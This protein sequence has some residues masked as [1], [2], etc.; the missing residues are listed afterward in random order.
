MKNPNGYGSVFKL[1]GKRRNPF[2]V[3]ITVGWE[4]NEKT[5]KVKQKY[6]N[7]GYYK[8]RSE[9]MIALAEYNKN[10]Y[11]I[12]VRKVTFSE[13]YDMWFKEK[14]KNST[15][16]NGSRGYVAAFNYS[17]DMHNMAFMDIRKSHMQ[18]VIDN[19]DKS[20]STKSITKTLYSQL[21]K[22]AAE[23]DIVDKNYSEFVSV[24]K[25]QHRSKKQPFSDA[26][27]QILWDNLE[28]IENVD[29]ALIMIYTGL[30]PGE[31]IL[32]E[33]DNINLEERYFTGGIKTNA[34]KERII[35]INKKIH[36]LIEKRMDDN[37]KYLFVNK[38]GNK[39]TYSSFRQDRWVPLMEKLKLDHGAHECRHTFA[40]LMDNANANKLSIKK[41]MGHASSDI[42]DKVYTHKNIEEL[43]KA[44]DLI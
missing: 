30:R 39:I 11:D 16:T 3:R 6:K 32:I 14:F 34:G 40:T 43:L 38:R 13:V 7:I 2:G 4:I 12:D 9:A 29:M 36:S 35:P 19:M 10:P 27:I 33:N 15:N 28:T 5:G 41:I 24:G 1:S 18:A 37:N 44:I 8:S 26:E 42:T 31:L 21:Y 25:N 23:N 20:Y 22:F 17:K